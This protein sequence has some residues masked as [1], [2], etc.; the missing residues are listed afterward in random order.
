[1]AMKIREML[2]TE[3][4]AFLEV[5]HAAVHNIA[6]KDYPA[7]VIEDW[8]PPI[9]DERIESFLSN[10]D[11][12]I[13]LVAI[14][15]GRIAG[16]GALVLANCELRACYVAPDAVRRGLGSAIVREIERFARDN[17]LDHLQ[18]DSS[19]TAEPFYIARGFHVTHRGQ[20][21]L[22]SGRHMASVKMEKA[23]K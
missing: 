15:D 7:E 18:L 6:S 11:G 22:R 10:P 5:H 19:V 1:M 17:G 21:A 8:A 23:L 16:V 12:E 9:T 2:E 20:H 14:I 3:A 13:R 4:R